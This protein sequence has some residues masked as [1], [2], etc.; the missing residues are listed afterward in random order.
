MPPNRV[1]T[2][3]TKPVLLAAVGSLICLALTA[4]SEPSECAAA[5]KVAADVPLDQDNNVEV[6][7]TLKV[8][9][10]QE[11][12][13]ELRKNPEVLGLDSVTSQDEIAIWS[14][15]CLEIEPGQSELCD[16]AREAGVLDDSSSDE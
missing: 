14:I 10:G 12:G 16:D 8:C 5:M 11:W 7:E 4:C 9:S 3:G 15:L 1:V 6:I 2:H 13:R